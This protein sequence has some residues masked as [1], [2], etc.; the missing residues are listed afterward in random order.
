MVTISK[1]YMIGYGLNIKVFAEPLTKKSK[2]LLSNFL[3]NNKLII[4]IIN[5]KVN[6]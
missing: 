4:T 2:A 3:N 1:K 6:K 5:R